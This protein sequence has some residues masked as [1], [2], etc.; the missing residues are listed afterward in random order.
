MRMAKNGHIEMLG[1][2]GIGKSTL[3]T[4]IFNDRIVPSSGKLALFS[5]LFKPKYEAKNRMLYNLVQTVFRNRPKRVTMD[6]LNR[7]NRILQNKYNCSEN[8]KYFFELHSDLV[9]LFAKQIRS[10]E[11]NDFFYIREK[12]TIFF[13]VSKRLDYLY[14]NS[15]NDSTVVLDEGFLQ[16]IPELFNK[17]DYSNAILLDIPMPT[18]VIHIHNNYDYDKIYHNLVSR[19]KKTFNFLSLDKNQYLIKM[20]DFD[21]YVEQAKILCEEQ[22]IRWIEFHIDGNYKDLI[23]CLV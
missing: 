12:I 15:P 14:R 16:V 4:K 7:G 6:Y 20:R 18:T 13:E 11:S 5:D 21:H 17:S 2:S 23:T 3:L 9:D 8:I 19:K 1:H 22:N 10:I